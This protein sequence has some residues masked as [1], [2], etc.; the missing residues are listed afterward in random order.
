MNGNTI[1]GTPVPASK[2][3]ITVDPE[4]LRI[5]DRW[6][7]EWQ[8]RRFAQHRPHAQIVGRLF[9]ERAIAVEQTSHAIERMDDEP[10]QY[11]GAHRVQLVLERS[12]YAEV[13]APTPERP[14]E[15]RIF[16]SAGTHELTAR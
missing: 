16:V 13:S 3:A 7:E 1:G 8:R 10:G 2:I 6:V 12:D 15:L 14:E 9:R 11:L 4:L 5:V